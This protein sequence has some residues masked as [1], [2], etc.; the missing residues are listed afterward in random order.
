VPGMNVKVSTW[1]GWTLVH[2]TWNKLTL[3]DRRTVMGHMSGGGREIREVKHHAQTG[4]I[5]SLI[6]LA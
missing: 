6:L 1:A 4:I 5:E 3:Q 2:T